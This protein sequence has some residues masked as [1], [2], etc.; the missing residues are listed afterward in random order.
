MR[1]IRTRYDADEIDRWLDSVDPADV[2]LRDA[3]HLRRIIR[4]RDGVAAAEHELREA[5][6]DAREAGDSWAIIA[7]GLGV[8]RQ[9][10]WE[11]FGGAGRRRVGG[12]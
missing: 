7:A 11:R 9:A 5:V 2:E 12:S 10:A 6:R 1:K 8:S 4:A 3:V